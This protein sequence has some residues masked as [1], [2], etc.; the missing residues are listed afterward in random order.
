MMNFRSSNDRS[1]SSDLAS[2]ARSWL[3]DFMLRDWS[4]KL[5]ALA[6]AL[7]LWFGVIGQRAPATIRLRGVQLRF[8]LPSDLE[9][10]NDTRDEVDV[11]LSGAK[12][13]LDEISVRDLVASVDIRKLKP[14]DRVARLT[15]ETV[16]MELPDGVAIERIEPASIALR[17]ERSIE[18][19]VEVEARLDGQPAAGY[20]VRGVQIEPQRIRVRGPESH[21]RALEH[22]TTETIPL[23]GTTQTITNTQ[24]SVDVL[25]Q[26]L[27]ALTPNVSVRVEIGERLVEKRFNGVSVRAAN[28]EAV[29]QPERA[30]VL[31]RAPVSLVESLRAENLILVLE[32]AS[33]ASVIPRLELTP[34]MN[35]QVELLA[36]E[37]ARFTLKQ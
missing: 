37:P 6:I 19:E 34:G 33:D 35:G 16:T 23:D 26:K 4:L 15:R 21:V 8:L 20:E 12:R 27:V 25:D 32:Y 1:G 10:S 31:V 18:R 17:V 7:G 3:R 36:T 2:V 28:G 30:T 22:A 14:G 24:T 13:A 11:T 29:A 9:I 5:L